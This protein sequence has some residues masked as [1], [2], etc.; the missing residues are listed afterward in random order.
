MG[1]ETLTRTEPGATATEL[2]ITIRIS[3]RAPTGPRRF[4]LHLTRD[5]VVDSGTVTF[6]VTTQQTQT[7]AELPTGP[8]IPPLKGEQM[9]TDEIDELLK[10]FDQESKKTDELKFPP[11]EKI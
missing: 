9:G 6:T 11:E 1:E 8:K 7:E 2:P 10:R 5:R 4:Q 3:P